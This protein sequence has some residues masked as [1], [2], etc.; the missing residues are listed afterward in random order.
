[1]HLLILPSWYKTKEN[2]LSGSFFEDQ[3]RAL[4]GAGVKVSILFPDFRFAHQENARS[5]RY[6]DDGIQ[7]WHSVFNA[8]FSRLQRLNYVFFGRFCQEQFRKLEAEHGK[9]D[10]LHAHSVFWGGLAAS[11]ISRKFKVPFVITEHHTYFI[12]RQHVPASDLR[13]AQKVFSS[14]SARCLISSSFRSDLAPML[15]MPSNAFEVVPEMVAQVFYDKPS[16]KGYK[17]GERLNLFTV[18][19]LSRRKNT[20]LLLKM[21]TIL[22]SKGVDFQLVIGG[23]AVRAD[24][25]QY[26]NE[27]Q[28]YVNTN[29]LGKEVLFAGMLSREEVLQHMDDCHI[30]LSSSLYETFGISLAE[31][32]AR[33]R[34]VVAL[35]SGGPR[36]FINERN[37]ILVQKN[38]PAVFTEAVIRVANN[39]QLYNQAEMSVECQKRYSGKQIAETL[40]QLYNRSIASDRQ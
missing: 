26:K 40:L 5:E 6:N 8:R 2:P 36:D 32:L 16:K 19:F 22:K 17:A 3:A 31:A 33:G 21:A 9:V 38:E 14:A 4:Q 12:Y 35:D 15:G 18:S 11:S 13:I 30:Y 28:V 34:P 37:G 10:V 27:L 24:E 7:T 20:M 23:D 29:G 1:M 25:I 39:Y